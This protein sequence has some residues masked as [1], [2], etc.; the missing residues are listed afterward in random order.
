MKNPRLLHIARGNRLKAAREAAGFGSMREAALACGWP[1]STYRAHENG[2]RTLGYDD[3]EKYLAAFRRRGA[4]GF[5]EEWIAYGSSHKRESLDAKLK[6]QPP[7]VYE[8]IWRL[9]L[10]ELGKNRQED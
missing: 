1:E 9:A 2:S 5:T 4:S 10:Q 3:I 8:A 7:E 6:D